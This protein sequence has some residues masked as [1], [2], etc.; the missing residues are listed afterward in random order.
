[1]KNI[2]PIPHYLKSIAGIIVVLFIVFWLFLMA[3]NGRYMFITMEGE[4]LIF[5][6]WTRKT[7]VN[8][9]H[10]RL[11]TPD[12]RNRRMNDQKSIKKIT[13]EFWKN[14]TDSST[15]IRN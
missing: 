15:E 11:I 3:L 4:D 8:Y 10:D 9:T 6:T 12:E 7:Y 2:P 5:D 1:M 14:R 13:E